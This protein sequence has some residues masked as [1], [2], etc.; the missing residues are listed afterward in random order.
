MPTALDQGGQG[1]HPR[2][3]GQGTVGQRPIVVRA[4]AFDFPDDLSPR[5]HPTR[6]IRSHLFNAFSLQMPFLEPFM[7]KAMQD[8]LALVESPALAADIRAFNAQEA[9]HAECHRR[10]NEL[11]KKNGYAELASVEASYARLAQRSLRRRLAFTLGFETATNG[12]T[13]WLVNERRQLFG[14]ACP[15]VASFWLM[16]MVEESEHR[17]VAFDAYMECFGCY[18]PRALGLIE[19]A[20]HL[21]GFAVLAMLTAIKKDEGRITAGR[22][23]EFAVELAAFVRFVVPPMLRALHPRYNPRHEPEPVWVREW[24]AGHAQFPAGTTLP[25]IDTE[26]ASPCPSRLSPPLRLDGVAYCGIG[27]GAVR[28]LSL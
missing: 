23:V 5:W 9:R 12:F 1:L 27:V 26:S 6:L 15:Y 24:T 11:V 10:F 18:L 21:L 19:S 17:N 8:A 25:L 4:F 14:K 7:I 16:H 3:A 2:V 28:Y 22:V 13:A 20:W